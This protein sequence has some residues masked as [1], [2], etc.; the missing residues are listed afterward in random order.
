MSLSLMCVTHIHKCR[1]CGWVGWGRGG[2]GRG[3]GKGI[4]KLQAEAGYGYSST[5]IKLCHSE[6]RIPAVCVD[7]LHELKTLHRNTND[8]NTHFIE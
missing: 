2:V 3:W 6:F 7:L 5:N 8:A 4:S 1:L